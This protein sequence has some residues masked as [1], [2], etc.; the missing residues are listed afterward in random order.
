M[1]HLVQQVSTHTGWRATC[2][3]LTSKLTSHEGSIMEGSVLGAK[4]T[5][6]GT[7]VLTFNAEDHSEIRNCAAN[8]KVIAIEVGMLKKGALQSDSVKEAIAKGAAS[9]LESAD[10]SQALI[11]SP[12]AA[13]ACADIAHSY[14]ASRIAHPE[15]KTTDFCPSYAKDLQSMLSNSAEISPQTQAPD[16][17]TLLR[18]RHA[19]KSKMR[20]A[21][22]LS[23]HDRSEK[24][25]PSPRP[26]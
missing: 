21:E 1:L 10:Q 13:D 4:E 7:Q 16:D 14:L 20:V 2:E 26:A 18:R 6:V 9:M 17:A 8:L 19:Q 24:A 11:D 23:A 25:L 3:Q 12:W 5:A 15:M 22:A